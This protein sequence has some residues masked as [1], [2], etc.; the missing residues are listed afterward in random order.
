MFEFDFFKLLIIGMIALLVL[1]PEKL[2]GLARKLGQ[3]AGRARSVARQLRT[4]LEQEVM[5]E[6][7]R[8][9]EKKRKAAA[10]ARPA[11]PPPADPAPTAAPVSPKPA[12]PEP[13]PIQSAPMQVAPTQAREPVLN[14]DDYAH[15]P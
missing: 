6:E 9:R 14:L 8:D 5:L 13:E 15:K 11:E 3:W 4:Q 10:E 2:P 7:E 12:S 1:G